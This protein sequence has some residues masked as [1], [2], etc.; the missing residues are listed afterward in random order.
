MTALEQLLSGPKLGEDDH[1]VAEFIEQT[2]EPA[3]LGALMLRRRTVGQVGKPGPIVSRQLG[4][5]GDFAERTGRCLARTAHRHL[6]AQEGHAVHGRALLSL[7]FALLRLAGLG[8]TKVIA[9]EFG[10]VL[11][12]RMLGR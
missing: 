12:E 8:R 1:L 10:H 3:D 11:V 4:L 7:V 6:E 5:L 9:H 2:E